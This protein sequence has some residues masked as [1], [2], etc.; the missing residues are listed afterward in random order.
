MKILYGLVLG[1][2]MLM[3]QYHP[4]G[5]AFSTSG[6]GSCPATLPFSCTLIGSGALPASFIQTTAS[7]YV[8]LVLGASGAVS[9]TGTGAGIAVVNG[10]TFPTSQFAQ[11]TIVSVGSNATGLCVQM[12]TQGDGQCF[13]GLANVNELNNGGGGTGFS[14]PLTSPQASGDVFKIAST[15]PNPGATITVTDVTHSTT[16]CSGTAASAS[17][18]GAGGPR[19]AVIVD[20]R[21]GATTDRVSGFTAD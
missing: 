17:G 19:A 10:V 21:S 14:C 15:G 4:A 2:L 20:N 18:G 5:P 16:V 8:A 11:G 13:I 6:G 7:S 3:G 12:D 1:C 9:T